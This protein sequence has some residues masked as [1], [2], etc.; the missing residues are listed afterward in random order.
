LKTTNVST[1]QIHK[2]TQA[3]YARELANGNIDDNAIYLT[4]DDT[5]SN[6][7]YGTEDLVAGTSPLATGTI[8]LVYEVE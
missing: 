4:Q 5:V 7:T 6:I 1:L 8:Y 3:Q 2:L